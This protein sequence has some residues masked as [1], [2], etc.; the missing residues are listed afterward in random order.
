MASRRTA[1]LVYRW[2]K[3]HCHKLRS[4]WTL[5]VVT[6][7]DEWGW[8]GWRK[9][10]KLEFAQAGLFYGLNWRENRSKNKL[11]CEHAVAW[12]GTRELLL[13]GKL[14]LVKLFWFLHQSPKCTKSMYLFPSRG[15][16]TWFFCLL[17]WNVFIKKVWRL[18]CRCI[19][20]NVCPDCKHGESVT[21]VGLES[22]RSNMAAIQRKH[23]GIPAMRY[24]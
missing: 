22:S 19:Y 3:V 13:S 2:S 21:I 16:R 18:H 17:I 23:E 5:P 9:W 8:G 10:R 1:V 14:R 20:R 6:T 15:I 7:T 11:V 24:Y 4:V 12:L